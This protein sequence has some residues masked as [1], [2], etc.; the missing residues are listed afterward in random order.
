[1]NMTRLK[2]KFWYRKRKSRVRKRFR[3]KNMSRLRLRKM[4]WSIDKMFTA[5]NQS[6][7]RFPSKGRAFPAQ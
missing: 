1:M 3:L 4:P 7:T 6:F 2:R 5:R